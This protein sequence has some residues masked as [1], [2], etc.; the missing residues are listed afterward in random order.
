M[1]SVNGILLVTKDLDWTSHDVCNFVRRRFNISKVGHAGTLDP[2]ATGV[3]VLLLGEFT[4]KAPSFVNC[5]KIYSGTLELGTVTA[6][7]DSEGDILEKKEWSHVSDADVRKV[8]QSFKGEQKQV[9]PMVSA[10]KMKGKRLYKL[11]RKGITIDR[12]PRDIVIYDITCDAVSLPHVDFTAHV[13]KG[14]YVR[15]I[16][17]DIGQ[18]L[19]TGAYLSRLCRLNVG[20]YS[21]DMCV[22][23][24]ELKSIE[25]PMDIIK[26]VR[27]EIPSCIVGV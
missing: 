22:T 3:L 17:H 2:K 23:I 20:P 24:D 9:P 12:E 19:G 21:K 27:S 13:S 4:K 14:T 25:N 26:Y 6:S 10:I 11:A 15:T 18:K 7:Q 5:D 8:I 16:A 1:S